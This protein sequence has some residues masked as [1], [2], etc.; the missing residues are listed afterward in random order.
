MTT[1]IENPG[2]ADVRNRL[3]AVMLKGHLKLLALGMK[4]S[5]IS[6]KAML[7]K[8]TTI[9]GKT[10]KRGAYLV[11]RADLEQWLNDHKN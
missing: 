3:M 6:G 2:A 4:N 5:K 11:A 1:T 8:T 7:E 9:T 10:Y